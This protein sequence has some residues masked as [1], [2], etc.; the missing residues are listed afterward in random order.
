MS[1]TASGRTRLRLAAGLATTLVLGLAVGAA[2]VL[3]P[4][5]RSSDQAPPPGAGNGRIEIAVS[6]TPGGP[7]VPVMVSPRFLDDGQYHAPSNPV[8][9]SGQWDNQGRLGARRQPNLGAPLNVPTWCSAGVVALDA[10]PGQ[11]EVLLRRGIEYVPHT[12]KMAAVAGKA[13]KNAVTLRRWVDMGKLGWWSGDD[14]VHAQI[15]GDQDAQRILTWARAEDTH[16]I[17]V[18]KMGDINRTWFEQRGWGPKHR[19][20][21]D[22]YALAPGQEC[23]RTHQELGHTLALNLADHMVRDTA[24]YFL[25]D[26]QFDGTRAQGGLVGYA[27]VNSGAFFVHRDMSLNVPRGKVDFVE[28]LQFGKSEPALYYEFLNLGMRLTALAGSDL[29]WG[30][31]IGEARAYAYTGQPRLS[32]DAWFDAVRRGRTFVTNGPMLELRVEE[33]YP[34]DT[35]AADRGQKLRVRA[36]AWGHR[37]VGLPRVL[38][39]VRFGEVI[40]SA[41]AAKP[42][43]KQ[44][45]GEVKLD[46]TIDAGSGFW[47]AARTTAFNG[48]L[49]HTTPVWVTRQGLRPWKYEAVDELLAKRL[50]SLRS[51]EDL[52]QKRK[53]NPKDRFVMLWPK[54]EERLTAARK[55]YDDLRQVA[56]QEKPLRR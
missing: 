48:S 34:G 35:I 23:P 11:W 31:S 1:A 28:L 43:A 2:P 14:H 32:A 46:F 50:A 33:A 7:A 24:Q 47:L 56:A 16:V 54:L 45:L 51:I 37:Q 25:Y 41:A 36:R 20:V 3:Y 6:D 49:A 40:R 42:D 52:Y 26:R 13:A 44:E 22:N 39:V 38:E 19:L 53:A 8:D 18:V 9:L 17:N 55:I 27:H 10:R 4:R 29:P 30:G 5:L 21:A 15:L 12:A